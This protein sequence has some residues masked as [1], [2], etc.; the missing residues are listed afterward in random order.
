MIATRK[1]NLKKRSLMGVSSWDEY[2]KTFLA[3]TEGGGRGTRLCI[4]ECSWQK[5]FLHSEVQIIGNFLS[6]F[7]KQDF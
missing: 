1:L 3:V 7:E 2:C 5:M 6:N 4:S